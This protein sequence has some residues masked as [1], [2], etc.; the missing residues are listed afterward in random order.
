MRFV[1]YF[2]IAV[3]VSSLGGC[4]SRRTGPEEHDR[5]SAAYRAGEFAHDLS[6]EAGKAAK[7]AGKEIRKDAGEAH[8][9][10]K[11]AAR[12]DRA[13]KKKTE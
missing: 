3:S 13:K 5:S 9:G 4:S 1:F 2:A 6:K 11:E 10:W 8:E 7:A 12:E